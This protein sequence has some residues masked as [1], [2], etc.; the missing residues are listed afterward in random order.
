ML[1]STAPPFTNDASSF[2]ESSVHYSVDTTNL[3]LCCV[4]ALAGFGNAFSVRLV[5]VMPVS[6]MVL[7]ALAA[8]LGVCLALNQFVPAPLIATRLFAIFIVGQTVALGGYIF[9]DLYRGSAPG[10]MI[11]GWARMLFL[12]VDLFCIAFLFGKARVVFV[13]Y[14]AGVAASAGSVLVQEPLFGD[15]WKFGVGYPL[16][17]LVLVLFPTFGRFP[18]IAGAVGIA[19]VHYWMDYRSLAVSCLAVGALTLLSLFPRIIRR[20]L[21]FAG[22]V[23][24][25]VAIPALLR[26]AATS[27]NAR[28]GRSN[29]ERSAM[30]QAAGEAVIASPFIGQGSW[31]S[32]SDVMDKFVEL[33]TENAKLAGVGG[34]DETNGGEMAIHSQILVSLAEGGCFG[35]MFF[36]IYGC[37]IFWALHYCAVVREWDRVTT[38]SLFLLISSLCALGFSPFSGPARVDIAVAT[39]VVLMLWRDR[40]ET[41]VAIV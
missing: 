19:A 2:E 35:G 34:F 26:N 5:G 11:R 28:H 29:A 15:Y 1:R 33:R 30:I 32:R 13:S 41:R 21:T 4:A 36:V 23:G 31:F 38:A 39:G 8:Y 12:A 9:S 22:V 17:I 40:A 27:D 18:A 37:A 25:I 24:I 10:D 7:M 14:L 6:E 16:T 3:V 20:A